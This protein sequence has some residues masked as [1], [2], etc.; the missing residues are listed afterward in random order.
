MPRS[1]RNRG[2]FTT[3]A[4]VTRTSMLGLYR[5]FPGSVV[6]GAILALLAGIS[7]NAQAPAFGLASSGYAA[8]P[9]AVTASPGQVLVIS[10]YG[11]S[12]TL[13]QPLR[14]NLITG[15]F[16]DR[17]FPTLL[18]GLSAN[19]TQGATPI[20]VPLLGIS[21][22]RCPSV[23][24]CAVTNIT[25]QVP[26]ELTLPQPG[27]ATAKAATLT[28]LEN[29]SPLGTIRLNPVSDNIH[30]LSSCD[31]TGIAGLFGSASQPP[32]RPAVTHGDG[33]LV[34]S[35]NPARPGEV[36]VMYAYGLGATNPA[37]LTG[38]LLPNQPLQPA[39]QTFAL[40]FDF[41][42]N[43]SASAPIPVSSVLTTP[44]FSG[45][46]SLIGIYQ[47]NFVVPIVPA[48]TALA[49]CD[50]YFITSN[51]TVTVVGAASFGG[52]PICITR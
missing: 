33:Q 47:V 14:S 46:G 26:Y 27:A 36:A 28:V 2:S 25:L 52:A 43:S 13:P 42:A 39:K 19:F 8:P 10:V 49:A 3:G 45:L 30:V 11:V 17:T 37:A 41:R 18:G 12:A 15:I 51:L 50:G 31:G 4:T 6:R 22:T 35:S 44:V 20:P 7:S 1:G 29:G 21:Q 24:N 23:A 5:G 32:C 16:N 48:G 9:N 40:S 34:T 38:Q